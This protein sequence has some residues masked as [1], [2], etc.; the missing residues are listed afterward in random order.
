MKFSISLV[1]I[2]SLFY[3]GSCKSNK[4]IADRESAFWD[5]NTYQLYDIS[6]DAKYAY[7]QGFPVKV[8][9]KNKS[10]GPLNQ[11]RYLNALLGPDGEK[12][13]FKHVKSCCYKKIKQ[14]NG[15]VQLTYLDQYQISLEGKKQRFI[16]FLSMF[17]KEEELLAPRGFT[18]KV[19]VSD[20][21]KK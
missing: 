17:E 12:T 11:R 7:T 18:F 6:K 8:G 21:Q 3:L 9:G 15:S 14:S 10:E 2:V 1:M 4:T 19:P 13:H 16:I 20:K 5:A